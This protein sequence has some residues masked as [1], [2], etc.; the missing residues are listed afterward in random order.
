MSHNYVGVGVDVVVGVV[1]GEDADG[2]GVGEDADG[3]GLGTGGSASST[4]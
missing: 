2:V 4:V 1:V 3:V